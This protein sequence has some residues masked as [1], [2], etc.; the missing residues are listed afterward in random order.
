VLRR[1][2]GLKREE[3]EGLVLILSNKED[4]MAEHV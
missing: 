1:I 3:L 4:K 2:S